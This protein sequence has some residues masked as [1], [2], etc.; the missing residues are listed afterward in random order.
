ML[1][2][3]VSRFA[4]AS[5]SRRSGPLPT[6][7]RSRWVRRAPSPPTARSHKATPPRSPWRSA[8]TPPATV[9]PGLPVAIP[10]TV[11]NL[12]G[13]PV[14]GDWTDSLYL[15]SDGVLDPNDVLLGRFAH[16]GGLAGNASYTETLT[17]T[18]PALAEG[19]Y[20]VV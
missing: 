15:S 6:T 3:A 17:A 1:P 4:T 2:P 8:A 7:A 5:T 19:N 16:H 18:V 9:V 11:Q 12:T 14:V 10:Y 13:T 20:R